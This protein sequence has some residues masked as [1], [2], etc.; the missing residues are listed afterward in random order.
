MRL[1]EPIPTTNQIIK[2]I[3]YFISPL[4]GVTHLW[5]L[6]FGP[7]F[8]PLVWP[9]EWYGYN[10][11]HLYAKLREDKEH[12]RESRVYVKCMNVFVGVI[13][14]WALIGAFGCLVCNPIAGQTKTFIFLAYFG[15]K[16]T[17]V[18]QSHFIPQRTV[19]LRGQ[20]HTT[21]L[22][23]FRCFRMQGRPQMSKEELLLL[24]CVLQN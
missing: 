15:K 19:T 17:E 23:G 18:F 4:M 2:N 8:T 12:Q 21:P 11:R 5:S 20:K 13:G 7:V 3:F 9:H 10:R 24:L 14:S 1:L 6:I 22:H 16:D